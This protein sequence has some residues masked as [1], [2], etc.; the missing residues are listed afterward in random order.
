MQRN[1]EQQNGEDE[2]SQENWSDQENIL[3]KDRLNKGQK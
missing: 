3:Y 1:R 2:K